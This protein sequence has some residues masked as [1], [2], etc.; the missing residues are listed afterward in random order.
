MEW[1]ARSFPRVHPDPGAE[2]EF[3]EAPALAGRLFATKPPGK[4]GGHETVGNH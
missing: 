4:P 2:L 3:P 1:V